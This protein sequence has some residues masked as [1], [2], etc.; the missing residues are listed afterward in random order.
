MIKSDR[1]DNL[2]VENYPIL[3]QNKLLPVIVLFTSKGAGVVVYSRDPAVKIG[4][5]SD[6]RDESTYEEFKG[7][8]ILEND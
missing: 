8:I 3:K 6:S 5:F 2:K 4:T 7:K 1:L